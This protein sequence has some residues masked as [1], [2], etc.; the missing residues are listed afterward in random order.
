MERVQPRRALLFSNRSRTTHSGKLGASF[1][2]NVEGCFRSS[3]EASEPR[4]SHNLS[5]ASLA[6]L[7]T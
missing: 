6:S 3:T 7:G 2:D 4:R 5:N 1:I